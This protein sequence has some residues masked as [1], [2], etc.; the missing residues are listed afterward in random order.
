MIHR[1]STGQTQGIFLQSK[2]TA[3]SHIPKIAQLDI[4]T[5]ESIFLTVPNFQLRFFS[6]AF[7]F[8]LLTERIREALRT[9]MVFKS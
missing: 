3:I 7:F 1:N 8:F 5:A 6:P 2:I 4:N 9:L